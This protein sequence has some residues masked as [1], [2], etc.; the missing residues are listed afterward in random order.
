MRTACHLATAFSFFALFGVTD[1]EAASAEMVLK[2]PPLTVEAS[3]APSGTVYEAG[4][5]DEPARMT[6]TGGLPVLSEA[7]KSIGEQTT[8]T[9]GH[10]AIEFIVDEK[11]AVWNAHATKVI[12][13]SKVTD[14]EL[15]RALGSAA[16]GLTSTDELQ[17]AVST[18]LANAVIDSVKKATF[19][20]ARKAGK[21]VASASSVEM[22]LTIHARGDRQPNSIGARPPETRKLAPTW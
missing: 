5:V 11:G 13:N 6:K 15:R 20:P 16:T 3:R 21:L 14:D 18:L 8:A 9:L 19:R 2:L 12:L 4:G 7:I 1:A 17:M 10:V 22:G